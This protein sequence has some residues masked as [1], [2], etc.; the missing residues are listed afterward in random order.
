MR[1]QDYITSFLRDNFCDFWGKYNNPGSEASLD[2]D[3]PGEKIREALVDM[4]VP[5]FIVARP[6]SF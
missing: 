4:T 6:D 2:C 1:I 5:L 3:W